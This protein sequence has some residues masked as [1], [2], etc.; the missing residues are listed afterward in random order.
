VEDIVRKTLAHGLPTDIADELLRQHARAHQRSQAADDEGCLEAV[1]KYAEAAIRCNQWVVTA[2]CVPLS[3]RLPAFD[4][5]VRA[6]E[7][8]QAS[9]GPESLRVI[10]PRVLHAIYTIRSKRGGGHVSGDVRAERVDAYLCLQMADW[11]LAELVRV[12][13]HLPLEE[14]QALVESLVQRQIP[15]VYRD[16]HVRLVTRTD[17]QLEDEILV[18]LYSEPGGLPER[19]IVESSGKPRSSVRAAIARLA[20]SRCVYKTPTNPYKLRL[21]PPGVLRVEQGG[22]LLYR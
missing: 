3:D 10:T 8:T 21:L 7:S 6:I 19:D 4:Q 14:G 20:R 22:L 1:G 11:F 13:S 15:V 9:A 2:S 12:L 18:L 16:E 17:L 5:L